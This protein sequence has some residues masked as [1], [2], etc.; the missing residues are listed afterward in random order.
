MVRVWFSVRDDDHTIQTNHCVDFQTGMTGMINLSFNSSLG[1]STLSAWSLFSQRDFSRV[2][3]RLSGS[4]G[5]L[6]LQNRMVRREDIAQTE[7]K[8]LKESLLA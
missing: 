3:A 2:P 8:V 6:Q 4:A 1:P 5:T 7:V